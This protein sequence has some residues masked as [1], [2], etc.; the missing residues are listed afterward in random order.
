MRYHQLNEWDRAM[1]E[2]DSK[3]GFLSSSTQWV[4]HIDQEKQVR[5]LLRLLRRTASNV[6]GM[7]KSCLLCSASMLFVLPQWQPCA[8]V[9]GVS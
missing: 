7:R 1:M 2:L 3:T 5:L 4:T 6:Y 9:H 8:L